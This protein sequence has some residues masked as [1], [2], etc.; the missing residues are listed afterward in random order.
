VK[1]RDDWYTRLQRF[2]DGTDDSKKAMNIH[3]I[4]GFSENQEMMYSNPESWLIDC[5]EV[6]AEKADKSSNT[7]RFV[8]LCI[9]NDLFGV[10]YVDSIFGCNVYFEHGQWYNDVLKTEIGTLSPPDIDKSE[11]WQLTKRMID[12][13]VNANVEL[14]VYGL[15]TVASTLNTAV[16]LYGEEIL[17]AM[18][19]KPQ[20]AEHDLRVINDVLIELHRRMIA[21]LP[22]KQLQPVIPTGRIQPPGFGQICGCTTQLISPTCYSDMIAQLDDELLGVYPHGGM[23]HLCGAHEHHI[24]VFKNMKNLHSIQINDRAAEGLE[25]YYKKLRSDQII[26]LDPCEKMP[27]KKAIEIT[28]GNRLVIVG[29]YEV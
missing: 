18:M 26:Y 3:G 12:A 23:M 19:N 6:L 16:N 13:F 27:P 24:P 15:P 22:Q 11:A 1:I 4:V 21:L 7:N 8:P 25:D 14:P 10:H 5:L 20:D 2:F 9:H 17:V 28:N 29:D